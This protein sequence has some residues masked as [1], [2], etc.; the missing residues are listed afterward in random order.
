MSRGSLRDFFV[1]LWLYRVDEIGEFDSIL[2][3][4]DWGIIANDVWF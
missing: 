3:E 2:Y 1:W 4:E